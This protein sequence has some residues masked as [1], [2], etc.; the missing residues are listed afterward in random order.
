[1]NR[2]N[3][4]I[5]SILICLL[6][7]VGCTKQTCEINSVCIR[8]N[9]GNY[10]LKWE[11]NPPMDGTMRFYVSDTP[12][13]FDMSQPA[14][15][16]DI[17]EEVTTYIT[18]DNLKRKFFRLTFNGH[19]PQDIAA[20]HTLMD[21]IQNFRD[22]GGY[23]TIKG[24]KIK[25]GKI[26]RSGFIGKYTDRDSTRISDA[27]IKT[28]ID[29]RTEEE[30][31]ENPLFFP[32]MR[33]VH[34]PIPAGNRADILQ[35]LK[36]NKVR[37]RDG[38][39]FLEDVYIKFVTQYTEDFA[40]ILQLFVDESNYPILIQDDLGKDRAGYLLSLVMM[41][42]DIPY[43]TVVKDYMESN[44]Y[45][46][47][48]FMSNEAK[49]L[50]WDAQETMTVMLSVN[51]SFLEVAYY[52]I[53]RKYGSFKAFRREGLLFSTKNKEKLKDILLE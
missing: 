42:L 41:L 2:M 48:L 11:T 10:I 4:R 24:R 9:I 5:K 21:S 6:A 1:M 20:R 19:Y 49:S 46:N 34:I 35:R 36:E 18:K 29:L 52:E 16:A 40:Q 37:S 23:K 31:I 12:N 7:L 33:I 44:K 26:Y 22:E 14:G 30:V 25:W 38:F 3:K 51:E 50:S 13:S 27:G 53:D 45:V 39:L 43:E 32:H 15:H 47:P 8:D 28:I 17:K